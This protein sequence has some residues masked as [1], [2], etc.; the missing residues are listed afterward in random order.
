MH[1][2]FLVLQILLY[3]TLNALESIQ[4][5]KPVGTGLH[6][7]TVCTLSSVMLCIGHFLA[8]VLH[9]SLL[10]SVLQ[11]LFCTLCLLFIWRFCL[12]CFTTH[13]LSFSY[14]LLFLASPPLLLFFSFC[15]YCFSVKSVGPSGGVMGDGRGYWWF[16]KLWVGACSGA[17]ACFFLSPKGLLPW[18]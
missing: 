12:F 2:Y 10:S 13:C 7:V 17:K 11:Y 1:Q 6:P 4:L 18:K 3:F 16:L 9:T 8:A 14:L 5:F 15:L